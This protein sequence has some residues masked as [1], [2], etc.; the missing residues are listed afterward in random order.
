LDQRWLVKGMLDSEFRLKRHQ[1]ADSMRIVF[2]LDWARSRQICDL[3]TLEV[4]RQLLDIV[5][6]PA[7]TRANLIG[8][9][10]HALSKYSEQLSPEDFSKLAF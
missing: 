3:T 10:G 8:T 9:R 1:A 6:V 5:K 7:I 2:G 4:R